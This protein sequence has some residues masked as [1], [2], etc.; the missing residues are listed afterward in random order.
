MSA[1]KGMK[2]NR[3]SSSNDP[4]GSKRKVTG[5]KGTRIQ[6]QLIMAGKDGE[7]AAFSNIIFFKVPVKTR[8]FMRKNRL[9]LCKNR[10]LYIEI[11]FL[12]VKIDLLCL[13]IDLYILKSTCY[14]LKST[15]IY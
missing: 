1:K 14:A 10:L 4:W 5:R 9:V 6:R 3:S 12:S 7:D 11:D 15:F 13:K 8:L 2:R